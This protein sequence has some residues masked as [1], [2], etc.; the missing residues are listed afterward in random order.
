MVNST[1][2]KSH[3]DNYLPIYVHSL[4]IENVLDFDLYIFNGHEM[5]LFRSSSL[6]FTAKTRSL[7]LDENITHL[8]IS[9]AD[10]KQYQQHIRSRIDQI[11]SDR[12]IDDFTKAS[13]VYD[14]AKELV[15]TVFSDP[16]KGEHIKESRE[17]V[18][19]TVLYVLEGA[20]AFHNML[21]VMSFDYSL[22]SH[23]VNV[24]TF[25]LALASVAGIDRTCEL[26]E[27]GTG[28]LL[29]DVGKVK[30]PDNIL[31]KPGPLSVDEWELVRKHPQLGV[32]II[33]ETDMIPEMSYT[34]IK[35]H[36]ER[37]DG[38]GYPD[39]L[40][41]ADI[42]LYGSIVSIADVFDAMTTRRV[43]RQEQS[44]FSTLKEMFDQRGAFDRRLL[45]I[46]TQLMGPTSLGE[47]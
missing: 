31:Y 41:S 43:Y 6:P 9:R 47:L 21:R 34:P 44:S 10:R 39:G 3:L 22:Y 28:A 14:S 7:L 4:G 1:K 45:E 13:I 18:E 30:I 38:S 32:E 5:V 24:C 27:L 8:Y 25:S 36:H 26:I 29:H 35:Q 12:S 37:H 42:H 17:F 20:N 16:T 15:E 11:L 46:F 33:S 2:Q 40:K 19:S 23:S